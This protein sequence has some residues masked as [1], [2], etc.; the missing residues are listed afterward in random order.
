MAGPLRPDLPL[1][2][3]AT[4]DIGAAAADSLSKLD[5]TGKQRHELLVACNG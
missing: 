5:F 2:M 1:P 4:R 3:I